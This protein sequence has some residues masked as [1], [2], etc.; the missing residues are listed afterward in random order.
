MIESEFAA[1][2]IAESFAPT[3]PRAVVLLLCDIIVP[4]VMC[5]VS[6]PDPSPIKTCLENVSI[7][8]SPSL[9]LSLYLPNCGL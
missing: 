8:F 1:C 6:V 9:F 5:G 3:T 7:G 4:S 2:E